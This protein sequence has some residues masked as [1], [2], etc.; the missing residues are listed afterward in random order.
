MGDQK[1]TGGWCLQCLDH[2]AHHEEDQQKGDDGDPDILAEVEDVGF[3]EAEEGFFGW[4]QGRDFGLAEPKIDDFELIA[5]LFAETDGRLDELFDLLDF[6]G[7]A[8]L[9]GA[10][11][12]VVGA[13]GTVDGD[14]D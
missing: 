5:A 3:L 1:A 2:R 4:G 9:V 6:L 7:G 14:S 11:A 8:G 13:V 10:R 12:L